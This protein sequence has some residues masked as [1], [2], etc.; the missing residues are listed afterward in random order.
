MGLIE[1]DRIEVDLQPD[2]T[3]RIRR[4]RSVV[5]AAHGAL[6]REGQPAPPLALE[7]R[8]LAA[9]ARGKYLARKHAPPPE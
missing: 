9:E 8:R 5:A 2:G 3:A 4:A 6:K 7:E 1:G